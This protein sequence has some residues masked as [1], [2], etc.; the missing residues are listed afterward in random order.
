MAEDLVIGGEPGDPN[1]SFYRPIAVVAAANGNI[2]VVEN[3]NTRVQMFGPD[4]EF[5]A[6]LGKQGQG[7]GEFQMPMAA[8]IAGEHLV[9][10]DMTNRRFS[11]WTDEGEHVADHTIPMTSP[12]N[13][14]AGLSQGRMVAVATEI[15][16]ASMNA[17][18]VMTGAMPAMTTVLSTYTREGEQIDRF[19]E[20]P[21]PP[22]PSALEMMNDPRARI[23]LMIDTG[24]FPRPTF[25]V[26]AEQIVYVTPSSE[27]QILAMTS[28]GA[29]SW[30]LRVAWPRPAFS[31][32]RKETRVNAFARDDPDI[33]VDDFEWPEFGDAISGAI[34]ADGHGRLYVFPLGLRAPP[35]DPDDSEEEAAEAEDE[36]PRGR[37][38]DIYSAEGELIIS[39]LGTGTWSYARGDFVYRLARD[40]DTDET[41]VVRSRLIVN[42]R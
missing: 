32:R 42:P 6:T 33:T 39:G 30:A 28:D 2:F 29:M 35:D 34:R 27:Y 22:M 38:V 40:P 16:M 23:Q 21:N 9:V 18:T 37:P 14:V 25:A 5:L 7:P 31:E 12:I 26:G 24:D 41:Q 19:L 11:V 36:E 15:D 1:T 17:E 13:Q 10:V 8:T 20:A 3:G 4:G